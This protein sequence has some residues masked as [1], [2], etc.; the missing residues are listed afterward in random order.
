MTTLDRV[1][2]LVKGNFYSDT[3]LV[4]RQERNIPSLRASLNQSPTHTLLP[5]LTFIQLFEVY[6]MQKLQ[7][8]FT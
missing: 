1:S 6:G 4:Q 3:D 8:P 2:Y 7:F 5:A